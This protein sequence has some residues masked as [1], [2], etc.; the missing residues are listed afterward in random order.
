VGNHT[1][2]G[3]G[4]ARDA[5][6][7]TGCDNG[8]VLEPGLGGRARLGHHKYVTY[9]TILAVGRGIGLGGSKLGLGVG[10]RADVNLCVRST[11]QLGG[12]VGLQGFGGE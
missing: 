4:A 2:L 1:H 10:G 9:A 6:G 11:G 7:V 12:V 3:C 8:A 5:V